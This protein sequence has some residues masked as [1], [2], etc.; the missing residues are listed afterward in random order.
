[1]D[2]LVSRRFRVFFLYASGTYFCS[3][4]CRLVSLFSL[5][6]ILWHAERNDEEKRGIVSLFLIKKFDNKIASAFPKRRKHLVF[7]GTCLHIDHCRVKKRAEKMCDR[8][9]DILRKKKDRTVKKRVRQWT[10]VAFAERRKTEKK[11]DLS[12]PSKREIPS[13]VRACL[14]I[15]TVIVAYRFWS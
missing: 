8:S 3:T 11:G 10:A 7:W 14:Y 4:D 9:G 6:Y 2:Q 5:F 1:M 15:N 12:A 13:E